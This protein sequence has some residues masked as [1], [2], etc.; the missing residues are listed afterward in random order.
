MQAVMAV[1]D[2]SIR[3]SFQAMGL[4]WGERLLQYVARKSFKLRELDPY[5]GCFRV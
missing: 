5:K 2:G 3:P 1:E 4:T